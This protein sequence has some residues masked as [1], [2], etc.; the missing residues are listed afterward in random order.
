M[1]S[2]KQFAL[3]AA[4]LASLSS[5]FG[6]TNRARLESIASA[7]GAG[8]FEKALE[9]VRPALQESPRNSQLWTLQGLALSGEKH[10]KEAM[11]SFRNALKISPDYVPALE[12]AAQL[13]YQS[14]SQSAVPLLEHL[15][16]LRPGDATSHAML[17]DLAYRRGDCATASQNFDQGGSVVASQPEILQE[18]GDCLVKLG[19]MEQ[20]VSVFQKALTTNPA[21]E[22]SRHRLAEVQLAA[23][24]PKDAIETL[25]PLL[26][27]T[28]PDATT[29]ELAAS[30]YE[31][32]GDTP[33]A[34]QTL[35]QA[36][37]ENAREID[38]Y[39]D[40]A[41]ISLDHQSFQVGIDMINAGLALQPEAAPLYVAR[42]VL[43]VQLEK[44]A[45]AEYDFEKADTID[46]QRSVGAA[47]R[48]LQAAQSNDPARALTTVRSKLASRPN[49][50]VLLYLQA[51]ILAQEGPEP[52]SKEFQAAILSAK[53]AV[54]L[55]PTLAPAHD[56]LAK[57]YLRAGQNQAA[58]E[59][60]KK[61][62]D[63]DPKDQT[64]LY[65]LIQALRKTAKESEIADL[66]KRLAELRAESTKL[67]L[68]HDRYKL[69]EPI[70][71]A[72]H[73][74]HP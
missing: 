18:Y 66:L 70:A 8:E 16:R 37:V 62:L 63:G 55:Q 51:D 52:G 54:A 47:A 74:P 10:P 58:I 48:G 42:G 35:R 45:E 43:Y 60:C 6:Q 53:R 20:A 39:L 41:K 12:G 64:A 61:A 24:R 15:L 56:V 44:Y 13:E 57:L 5:T 4:F 2:I 73:L 71:P 25:A 32:D 9:L 33:R 34:V 40:F 72:E 29:M 65:H 26:E 11:V 49:D 21:D 23:E 27:K 69:V 3:L 28:A 14:S 17:A 22:R 7:L 30:A 31:E 36:I 1:G 59:Q 46:P 67:E 19:H 50:P 38:L 68:Q